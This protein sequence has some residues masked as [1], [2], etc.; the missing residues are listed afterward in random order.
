MAFLEESCPHVGQFKEEG[1]SRSRLVCFLF[2]GRRF[3][4]SHLFY[5][6]LCYSHMVSFQVFLPGS[7]MATCGLHVHS[8]YMGQIAQSIS[9]LAILLHMGDMAG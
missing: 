9:I 5:L 8:Y 6:P 2:G 3:D 4:L 1:S 7:L